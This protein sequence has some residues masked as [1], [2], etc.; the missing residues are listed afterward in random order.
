MCF[1][2]QQRTVNVGTA[3]AVAGTRLDTHHVLAKEQLARTAH[4]TAAMWTAAGS[5][6]GSLMW[7]G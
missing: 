7:P 6:K 1:H 3:L 5:L 4:L 2:M